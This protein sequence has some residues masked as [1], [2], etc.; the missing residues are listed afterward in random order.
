M[1]ED[2][3]QA[4]R[5]A[6]NPRQKKARK[7]RAKS[8]CMGYTSAIKNTIKIVPALKNNASDVEYSSSGSHPFFSSSSGVITRPST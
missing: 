8:G 5:D 3:A 1:P 7:K 6:A 2:P 4:E